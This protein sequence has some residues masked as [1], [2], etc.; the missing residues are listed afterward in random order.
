MQNGK[1]VGQEERSRVEYWH[2]ELDEHDIIL[3]EGLPAESYLDNGNRTG[4][5]NGGAFIEAHP[6]FKPK[7]WT[8][9]CLP[10]VLEGPKVAEQRLGCSTEPKSLEMW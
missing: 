1:T 5:I 2:I 9:T 8:D 3:A 4:F 6:D 7:H 10:L